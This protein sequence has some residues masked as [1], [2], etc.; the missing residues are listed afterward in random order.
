MPKGYA[1]YVLVV[2]VGINFLNYLDRWVPAAAA[3]PIQREFHLDDQQ[4]GLL[5][6]AFLIVYA[7]GALPFGLW[8]DRGVRK[9]V[10]GTGVTVW[11][12]ATLL[13]GFA[14]NYFQL[15]VTRAAVGVG[16]A[17]Y[18][19]AGTALLGDY[20]PKG[21]R[22]RAMSI[23]NAGTALGIAVGFAGG[24]FVAQHWG[25]RTAFFI[26]AGPGLLFAVLA[27]NLREPLRGAAEERGPRLGVTEHANLGSLIALMRIR[28]L[29]AVILAQTALF[30]V[31]AANAFWLPVA[32]SRR[33]GLGVA[34]AGSVA[35]GVIVIGG[36]LGTLLGG[37]LGDY[38]SRRHPRG[39]LE[40]GIAGFL[41]ATVTITVALLTTSFSLFLVAF[42]LTV[43][44]LYL[45]AGPF[46]AISQNIV[47]PSLRA[48]ATTL[49]LLIAH[50]LGDSY[51]TY[52]VGSLSKQLGSLTNALLLVSP[53]LLL[54]AAAV[55][56]M[57]L[58]SIERDT[59]A[60]EQ[61]WAGATPGEV[62]GVA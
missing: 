53:A 46:V 29:R 41:L 52:V 6:A 32:L 8:A 34:A 17:S 39:N 33:F 25:W 49:T 50:L 57:G 37:W 9:I 7:L 42:F 11:S 40:V 59:A 21:A 45:Y 20:F 31:L 18:Y 30:F 61:A 62:P 27:F 10:I 16:E 15:F 26:T 3:M 48:S 23:W 36:L 14:R 28:T 5:G 55:A 51:S 35:G 47:V 58:G 44:F 38:R 4:L 60:M 1:R 2:M 24:A 13:T 19:P 22:S 43:I 56:A 12:L 54:A